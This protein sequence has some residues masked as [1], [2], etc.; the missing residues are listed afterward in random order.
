[1]I[2]NDPSKLDNYLKKNKVKNVVLCHGVFDLV[3]L[4]HL[5]YFNEA[6]SYGSYLVVSVTSDKFIKKGFGR[7]LFKQN[8]RMEYISNLKCVNAVVLS[9][10]ASAVNVIKQI[11][12]KFYVKGPDYK[13]NK[14]DKS[15][16]IFL[17]KKEVENHGGKIKYTSEITFSSTKLINSHNLIFNKEQTDFI[18][19]I[20]RKF[21]LDQIKRLI[22]SLKKLN[23][24][25]VGEIIFDEYNF[26]DVIGKSGKE[27]HL[28]LKEHFKETYAGGSAA[29]GKHV[30]SFVN[31]VKIISFFGNEKKYSNILS[32]KIKKN[33][34]LDLFRPTNKFSSIIKKRF[35]DIKS[36]YKLFGS[37]LLPREDKLIGQNNLSKKI[38]KNI[39]KSDL[40]IICDYGHGLIN[41]ETIKYLN[42]L[43]KFLSLNIQL[44]SSSIGTHSIKNYQNIDTLIINESELRFELKNETDDIKSIALNYF[45]Y[46]KLNNLVITR[47]ANGALLIDKNKIYKC[48]AFAI[49]S[50]DK[51]GAGDAMLS[52][53]SLCLRNK[54]D[55][56]LSLFFGSIAGAFSVQNLGN[57][58]TFDFEELENF[59]EYSL[60]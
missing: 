26:G 8:M 6:K 54:F 30:S 18:K 58:K 53:M 13:I 36:N 12:P 27:P 10:A 1:M 42:K 28:V 7:P 23:V 22:D 15:K 59:L 44:N 20:K 19:K 33:I 32:N 46:K 24:L 40:I 52:I 37:Y 34:K 3:H 57:K 38:K 25:V 56:D 21:S 49:K 2:F 48:P 4:G 11:K 39:N 14:N 35:I 45:K 17:E 9:D 47:G 41:K 16:K 29:I 5:K 31:S 51:V 50:V 60:K 55:K 43:N